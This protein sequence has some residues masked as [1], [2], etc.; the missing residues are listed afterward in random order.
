[1]YMNIIYI[2]IYV[3]VYIYIYMYIYTCIYTHGL[4]LLNENRRVRRTATAYETSD[5]GA[6]SAPCRTLTLLFNV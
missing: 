2:Y 3:Y 4:D 5:A 6:C 1:M